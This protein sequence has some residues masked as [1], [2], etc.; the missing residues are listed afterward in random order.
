MEV[1]DPMEN[2]PGRR[3]RLVFYDFGQAATLE[4]GQ[5]QGILEVLESIVDTDANQAV[6]A[7]ERMGVLDMEVA[8]KT[9]IQQVVAYNFATGKVKAN[10]KRL[11]KRGLLKKEHHIN[12]AHNSTLAME[13]NTRE[14]VSESEIMRYFRLP[15]SYAF[16]AR[17]LTQLDGVG[18]SLDPDFDFVSSSAPYMY[19]VRGATAFLKNEAQKFVS[20]KAPGWLTEKFR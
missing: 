20:K 12:I 13:A 14:L 16:V 15:A 10:R 19:E 1:L 3:F 6:E 2:E 17:A 4:S 18:K 11:A 7:F 9:Q 8:N 5:A